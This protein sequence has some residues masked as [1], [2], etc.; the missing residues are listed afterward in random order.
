MNVLHI[1]CNYMGTTL[2]S[3]MIN[4]LNKFNINNIV[5][6]P[7]L[8]NTESDCSKD[9][10]VI[11]SKCFNK[12]DRYF[13]FLKQYKIY[14]A[15]RQECDLNQIDIIH[16]YT[17]YTDGN[18]AYKINKL[19]KIPYVVTVRMTD[20]YFFR[21]RK[22]LLLRGLTILL[23]SNCIY[24]LSKKTL[25]YVIDS[26]IPKRYR[27]EIRSKSVVV[28]N[29]IDDYWLDNVYSNR[30]Y[31]Q[32]KN[33]FDT[34]KLN[35]LCVAQI[36]KRKGIPNI[37]NA[38][39]ILNS[40]GWSSHLTVI[41][42]KFNYDEFNI[43]ISNKNTTYIEPMPKEQLIEY[44]RQSDIFVLPSVRETFGLVYAEAMSQ[45]LPV[46]YTLNEGFDGQYMDG[47]VGY[48]IISSDPEDIAKK[49]IE[50]CCN[51]EK[52][53]KKC[54]CEVHRYRWNDICEMYFNA[55]EKYA[56]KRSV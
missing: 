20:I 19:F 29:G 12:Y 33:K 4:H 27:D 10:N 56:G 36:M 9:K 22:Y 34:K 46:L 1:N 14:K 55:Y 11:I 45:G 15:L 47:E 3:V 49:I 38:I 21:F 52:I 54:I 32:I 26:F 30:D 53:S 2:H 17:L 31:L 23:N 13:Y 41:G 50:V 8:K 16:A 43:I 6:C 5:F 28:K 37:Q 35:I 40:K 7:V 48:S 18:I 39:D 51:Y 24:F 42:K 44:Y 25:D